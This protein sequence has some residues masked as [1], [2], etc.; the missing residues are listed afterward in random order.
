MSRLLNQLYVR[1]LISAAVGL[2]FVG[3]FVNIQYPCTETLPDENITH[4]VSIESAIMHPGDLVNNKQDSL[5]NF[6]ENFFII[7]FASFALLSVFS[8]FQTKRKL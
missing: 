8:Q 1:V 2:F 3:A 6:V 7:S 4:C 5:T